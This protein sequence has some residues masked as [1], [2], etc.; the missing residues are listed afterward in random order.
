MRDQHLHHER[1]FL[2]EDVPKVPHEGK[3]SKL[4]KEC[5]QRMLFLFFQRDSRSVRKVP[6]KKRTPVEVH[7][8]GETRE[9]R[10]S[11]GSSSTTHPDQTVQ[12]VQSLDR[13]RC[14][15][16]SGS[17]GNGDHLPCPPRRTTWSLTVDFII[18]WKGLGSAQA[19]DF[20]HRPPPIS[21]RSFH[22]PPSWKG[23]PTGP[24][25]F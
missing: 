14:K 2:E 19:S 15:G 7:E 11:P 6:S 8:L 20:V 16:L 5:T 23:D 10:P 21:F 9:G 4:G 13:T 18:S 3:S 25:T 17:V 1:L 12:I 24:R 22:H